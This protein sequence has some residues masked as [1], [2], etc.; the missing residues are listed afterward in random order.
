MKN[1]GFETSFLNSDNSKYELIGSC[2][3]G[4]NSSSMVYNF[5]LGKNCFIQHGMNSS[6]LFIAEKDNK[7]IFKGYIYAQLDIAWNDMNDLGLDYI[8]VNI[9]DEWVE[10]GICN[11]L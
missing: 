1:L 3:F 2:L 7:Y 11:Y 8:N 10:N 5:K 4:F 6:R 9:D